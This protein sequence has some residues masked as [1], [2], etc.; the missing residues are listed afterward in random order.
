M[1]VL[2]YGGEVASCLCWL[3]SVSQGTLCV[4]Q[5]ASVSLTALWSS[6]LGT[7]LI[8]IA[9]SNEMPFSV[10][11]WMLLVNRKTNE[12]PACWSSVSPD[13]IWSSSYFLPWGFLFTQLIPQVISVPLISFAGVIFKRQTDWGCSSHGRTLG[14]RVWWR[15]WV[16]SLKPPKSK[17]SKRSHPLIYLPPRL[18]ECIQGFSVKHPEVKLDF[19][20]VEIV[21]PLVS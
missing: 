4:L 17:G 14:S 10:S 5:S 19:Y 20:W 3:P 16:Q 2:T 9:L 12:G 21:L 18:R 7:L 6:F 11:S 1:S 13:G 8:S 15:L